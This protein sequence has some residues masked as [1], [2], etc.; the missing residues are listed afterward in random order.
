M[1]SKSK[2]DINIQNNTHKIQIH[3]R[4]PQI[5]M[6]SIVML[7]AYGV[8]SGV[9]KIKDKRNKRKAEKEGHYVDETAVNFRTDHRLENLSGDTLTPNRPVKATSDSNRPSSR[10]QGRTTQEE[11]PTRPRQRTHGETGQPVR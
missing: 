3:S 7:T 9:K 1:G 6:G 5:I 11:D 2:Y 10:P 4:I 8:V